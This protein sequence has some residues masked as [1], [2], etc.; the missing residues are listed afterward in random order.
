[1][2]TSLAQHLA[3]STDEIK[4]M[5]EEKEKYDEEAKEKRVKLRNLINY[6][7][8]FNHQE[9]DYEIKQLQ[10]T[11]AKKKTDLYT[12]LSYMMLVISIT[13]SAHCI[14]FART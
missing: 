1:M 8:S 11:L 2:L 6:S 13:C 3:K 7:N 9:M 4:R 12:K 10:E 5:E 14:A